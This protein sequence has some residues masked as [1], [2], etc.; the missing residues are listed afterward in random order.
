MPCRVC[1]VAF[2]VDWTMSQNVT[3]GRHWP[4]S[5]MF[6]LKG[7]QTAETVW[8][9]HFFLSA[10][11]IKNGLWFKFVIKLEDKVHVI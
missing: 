4:M 10:D 2:R 9:K 8:N 11:K 1:H 3:W 5:V 7:T 6:H